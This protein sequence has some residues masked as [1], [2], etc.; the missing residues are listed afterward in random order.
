MPFAAKAFAK[1][2]LFLDVISKRED[3]YHELDS[4]FQSVGLYD[5]VG[6]ALTDGGI[7]VVCDKEELSGENNIVYKAC[8]LFFEKTGYTGGVFVSIKKNIPVAAGLAGGSADAAATLCLLNKALSSK[9]SREK[10]CE[11]GKALGAD[12]PFCITG[13]TARVQGIGEK[14][15][16]L[17]TPKLHYVLLKDREKQS[18][19]KMFEIIDSTEKIASNGIDDL[20]KGINTSDFSLIS[21]NLYNAFAY[22]W[23][24]EDMIKPFKPF[25][26]KGVFLS[27]SGP[28]VCALFE[29]YSQALICEKELKEKGFNAFYACSNTSGIE[30]V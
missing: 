21:N 12:V 27:G 15:V 22:C 8:K 14:I 30:F 19:G 29:N 26:P 20:L 23:D 28:T 17:N 5:E 18:T 4:V 11:L 6:I 3:G 16:S 7:K 24:F 2:N 25:S 1:I 9:F 13:G 10:L